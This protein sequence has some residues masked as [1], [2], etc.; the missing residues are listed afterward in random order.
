[1]KR[2]ENMN[3][4]KCGCQSPVPLSKWGDKRRGI[5]VGDPISYLKGHNRRKSIAPLC[6]YVVDQ[7]SGCWEWMLAKD[8]NGYGVSHL[9]GT[10]RHAHIVLWI[11]ENGEVAPNLELDHTC[12]NVGCVNPSHLEAVTPT[13]NKRRSGATKLTAAAAAEIKSSPL[14]PKELSKK[15]GVTESNI[16]QIRRGYSWVDVEAA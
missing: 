4:C 15:F 9:N 2:K 8:V 7:T 11:K 14:M 13:E 6:G 3:L 1:M 5:K 12:K 10:N 16:S